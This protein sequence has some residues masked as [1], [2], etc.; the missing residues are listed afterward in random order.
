MPALN[1]LRDWL[2]MQAEVA[3]VTTSVVL[4]ED[5]RR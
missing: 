5:F 2:A 4:N 1:E 3:A